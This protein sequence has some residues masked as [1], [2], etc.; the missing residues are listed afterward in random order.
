MT[1]KRQTPD[2]IN[3]I[4][5]FESIT[6]GANL[7]YVSNVI[8]LHSMSEALTGV[9][10]GVRVDLKKIRISFRSL[11]SST[12]AF[13]FTILPVLVQTA[14]TL[15]DTANLSVGVCDS[16][17][18]SACDDVFG[19]ESL[20]PVRT[21]KAYADTSAV[22]CD[23]TVEVPQKFLQLLNKEHKS[24]RLQDLYFAIVGAA[25][26]GAAAGSIKI[27]SHL[28]VRYSLHQKKIVIR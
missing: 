17:I 4:R 19:V 26:T 10:D 14:G 27:K 16:M 18:A 28:E 3:L 1:A 21:S 2:R 23:F 6:P 8:N 22:F 15:S 12:P 7:G 24:E 25:E 20:G 11:E 5:Y 9:G 13:Y